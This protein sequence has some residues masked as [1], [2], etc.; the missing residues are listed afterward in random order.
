MGE[1]KFKGASGVEKDA[2]VWVDGTYVGYVKELKGN[3]KVLLLPGRHQI[4]ARESGYG[5]FVT[6]VVIEPGQVQ[7]V[8]VAMHLL[9]GAR[10]PSI[11]AEL[12]LTVDPGR[13]AVFLDDNYAGHAGE[14]GGKLHSLLLSPGKHRIK[15]ELPG[16]RTFETEVT[17]Y[18]GQ[19]QEVKT[20]LVKGSIEQASP[21]IK[22]VKNQNP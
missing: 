18:A 16:Y 9:T 22:V 14:F 2:G 21:D 7:R 19:K 5:D 12:K 10:P 15:V 17:L 6:D 11:T 3:K 13:A 4:T 8:R 20:E 1:L